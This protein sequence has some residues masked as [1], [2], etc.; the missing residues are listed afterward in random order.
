MNRFFQN[1]G[2]GATVKAVRDWLKSTSI[3]TEPPAGK[4]PILNIDDYTLQILLVCGWQPA[5]HVSERM[6]FIAKRIIDIDIQIYKNPNIQTYLKVEFLVR[7]AR[8]IEGRWFDKKL[9]YPGHNPQFNNLVE[10][11][12]NEAIDQIIGGLI[13][14]NKTVGL[15][16]DIAIANLNLGQKLKENTDY[17][18]TYIINQLKVRFAYGMGKDHYEKLYTLRQSQLRSLMK[19]NKTDSGY[20]SPQIKS[21]D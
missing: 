18:R 13:P 7:N 5:E 15:I 8:W 21:L 6:V 10:Q 20:D 14:I 16:L 4:T 1:P 19:I 17:I 3:C 11:L 9:F 12:G 2:K